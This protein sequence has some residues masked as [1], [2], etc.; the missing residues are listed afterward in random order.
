MTEEIKLKYKWRLTWPE[1]EDDFSGYDGDVQFGRFYKFFVPGG[2]GFKW[3]WFFSA[4]VQGKGVA[5]SGL[6]ETQRDAAAELERW[7]DSVIAQQGKL[8]DPK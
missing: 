8:W 4:V 6:C 2:V 7:Y 1:K 3:M 5:R